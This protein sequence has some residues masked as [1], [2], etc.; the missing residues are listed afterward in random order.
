MGRRSVD[1]ER[2]RIAEPV[3]GKG[4]TPRWS[5]D[6]KRLLY[7]AEGEPKGIAD[8]RPLGRREG[9]ATQITHVHRHAAQRAVVAR[10]QVDRVLDVRARGR[11]S[12]RSPCR[13]SR[14]ARSGR[15]RR[16]VV[17]HDALPPGSGR[18]S[19][20]RLHAPVRR[21]RRRRHAARA[22]HGQVERRRGR[23][24]RRR[25]D[26]LDARQQDDRRSTAIDV[27]ATPTCSTRLADLF[28]VDVATGAIRE[29]VA[30]AATG[31]G[32]RSRPTAAR[33]VHRPSRR[34][35]HA[36]VSE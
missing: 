32:P 12:G 29:L 17:E 33:R 25:V 9:P 1:P 11:R 3:P 15:R 24:A 35:G 28:A 14:R 8:L 21:A 19:R 36:T 27:A 30:K 34:P 18:L 10:R 23:T 5:P 6:G 26:R 20:G 13:R 4:G 31:R 2:R 7:L 16:A 22:D